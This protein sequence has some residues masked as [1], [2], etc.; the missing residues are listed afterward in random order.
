[1]SEAAVRDRA[2]KQGWAAPGGAHDWLVRLLKI[3]LPAA[4]GLLAAYLAV[5]PLR[6]DQELSFI[7]DK[8]K[9]E[10]AKERLRVTSARYR[11]EDDLGRPFSIDAAGAVQATSRVPVVQISG[12]SAR[13]G[14]EEGPAVLTAERGAY[15]LDEEVV[16]V[17]GPILFTA[18]DGYRLETSDVSVD[19]NKRMLQSEGAV[20]GR[21]PLGRFTAGRLQA[22]LGERKVVLDG[23]ARIRIEQVGA[24]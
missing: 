11:G 13:L 7:F 12:M 24:R 9:V 8:N 16:D 3:A 21:V 14:L 18:A 5:V 1:M 22:D 19:L 6:R 2:R 17:V 15:N 4:I 20:A 23:R 10:V